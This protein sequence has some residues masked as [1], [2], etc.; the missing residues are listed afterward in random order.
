MLEDL[1]RNRYPDHAPLTLAVVIPCFRAAATITDVLVSIGPAVGRIYCV[2]DAS[3]DDT[4]ATIARSKQGDARIRL[5]CRDRNGG[6]G[7]ATIDGYRAAIADGAGII[8]KIDAD[9][10]M[11][12]SMIEA[13]AEPIRAGL[14]DY[15][16]GNRFYSA[17]TLTAMPKSRIIGNAGLSFLAKL[18]TG[19]WDL[20]DP[21]NGYTAIHSEIAAV[22]PLDRIAKRYFFESDLLF[23]LSTI[24]ARVVEI[25]MS[26]R[27]PA[28]NSHLNEWHAFWTFPWLHMRNCFKRIVYNYFLRNFS[29]ASL[30]LVA[31][32]ALCLFGA[33]YGVASWIESGMTDIPASAGTVMLSALPLL[34]GIQFLL[35]FLSHDIAM[36]PQTPIHPF[37]SR[38]PGKL[39]DG[40]PPDDR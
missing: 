21:T 28:T 14:A 29:L 19:Y 10:Q 38:L 7:A 34:V 18:S 6:V 30:N 4:A 23:R 22:L 40:Q 9:G 5:V 16:K 31:G 27:Y 15:V 12:T 26:A 1:D 13:I 39:P 36:V 37:I 25:P 2:D 33:A 11:D 8:I 24:R 3:D 20:F 35:S 17:Q 32:A